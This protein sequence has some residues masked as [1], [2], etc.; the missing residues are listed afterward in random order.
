MTGRQILARIGQA[1]LVL[2][3]TFTLAFIL[4]T[5]LPGDAVATRYADPELGLSPAQ[6]QQMRDVYGADEPILVRY[7]NSLTGAL[8]G[9]FG[10]SLMNGESV[11][12]ALGAALPNTL[13]L[14]LVAF[15]L[16]SVIAL[17]LATLAAPG[18][19]NRVSRWLA[20][21]LASVP[22]LLVALPAFWLGIILIQVFSFT[23]G[24]IPVIDASPTQSIILP[25]IA[26]A[27]PLS[28]PMAQ[29]LLRGIQDASAQPFVTVVRAR[30]ASHHWVLWRNVLRNAML[31]ALTIAGLTFGEL[32]GGAVV[33]EAVFSRAGIGAMTVDAVSNRDTPVLMAV[34]VIS[35]AVYVLVN[36]AVDLLY[37]VLDPRLRSRSA[38]PATTNGRG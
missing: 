12:S 3:A 14:A 19:S 20:N 29:V 38:Q 21:A 28:A 24:W 34:V 18:R 23:L 30:G 25:A 5:A 27:L 35:A 17:V 10:N 8:R 1:I 6:I 2:W 31:P 22:S 7:I 33:T 16:A 15:V 37:P 9:D 32:I 13:A 4:L 36:L 11:T 26:I